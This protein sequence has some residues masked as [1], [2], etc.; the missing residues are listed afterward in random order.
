M[1]LISFIS[2]RMLSLF[3][4][5]Y[6]PC[7]LLLHPNHWFH[8]QHKCSL[9]FFVR[10]LLSL[11]MAQ[12]Y[13]MNQPSSPLKLPLEA[14]RATLCLLEHHFAL[15]EEHPTTCSHFAASQ[16]RIQ[17]LLCIHTHTYSTE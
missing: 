11:Q 10:G 8:R 12:A 6:T 4:S 9:H 7:A 16:I 3:V 2:G 15:W 13:L 1:R 17:V 5:S 14:A